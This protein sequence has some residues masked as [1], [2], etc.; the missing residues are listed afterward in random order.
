M[1]MHNLDSLTNDNVAKD[2]EEGKDCRKRRLAIDDEK[3]DVVDLEA[4]CE[5]SHA[6]TTG[7]GVS[8]NDH[9]VAAVNEFLGLL[10]YSWQVG[11]VAGL[12]LESWYM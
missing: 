7:I 11:A 3:G 5:V 10:G 1:A 2:R 6:S 9:L 4:I 12:T 8:D